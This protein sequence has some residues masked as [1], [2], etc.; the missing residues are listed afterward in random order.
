MNNPNFY[1]STPLPGASQIPPLSPQTPLHYGAGKQPLI[2][3]KIH[4]LIKNFFQVTIKRFGL[5][6]QQLHH[7]KHRSMI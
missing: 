7:F 3:T 2:T 6:K 1:V 4:P 5:N